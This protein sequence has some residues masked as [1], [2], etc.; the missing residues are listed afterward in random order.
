MASTTAALLPPPL[1]GRVGERGSHG[2][3]SPQ[4]ARKSLHWTLGAL[5]VLASGSAVAK[6]GEWSWRV[7]DNND[8]ETLAITDTD[9]AGDNIKMPFIFC[10]KAEGRI[11]VRGDA[12]ESLRHAMADIIRNNRERTAK[13]SPTGEEDIE[14]FFGE[15]WQYR[16]VISAD[17]PPFEQF[18][19]TGVLQFK[20]G[21][22]TVREQ[23][24]VGMENIAKFQDICRL[25]RRPIGQ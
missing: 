11:T 23:F 9:L 7:F 10:K 16:I 21:R 1:W 18:K 19:R 13:L 4:W 17:A 8:E 2:S 5:L 15:S 25:K 6:E 24:T 22:A 12:D 14:L 20:L 3:L